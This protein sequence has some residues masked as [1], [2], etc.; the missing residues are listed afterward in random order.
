MS[1]KDTLLYLY[2]VHINKREKEHETCGNWFTSFSIYMLGLLPLLA[3][4]VFM[5]IVLP[6][7]TQFKMQ[8]EAKIFKFLKKLFKVFFKIIFF[9]NS[10][11]AVTCM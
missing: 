1:M 4:A 9:K 5:K 11:D 2:T 3:C 8:K 6:S 7:G 10:V